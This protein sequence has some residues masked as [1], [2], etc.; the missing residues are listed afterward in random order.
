MFLG[1]LLQVP[2]APPRLRASLIRVLA[3]LGGVQISS[4]LLDPAG[5]PGLVVAMRRG[6]LRQELVLA[7][8]TTTVLAERTVTKSRLDWADARPG[9]VLAWVAYL[10]SAAV[11]STPGVAARPPR[12]ESIR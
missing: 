3:G 9:R 1:E 8:R 11:G 2:E 4:L 5:R 12:Q 7:L 6:S 10:E